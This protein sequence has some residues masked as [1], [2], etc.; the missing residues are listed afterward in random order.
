MKVTKAA[1][2][3][4]GTMGGEIAFVIASAGIPVLLKDVDQKF[5]DHGVETARELWTRL[6]EKGKLQQTAADAALAL[7][8][9]TLTYDDFGSVDFVIE[10]VPERIEIKQSVFAELDATTPGHAILASNT[11]ALSIDEI[12]AATTRPDKVVGFHFFYPASVAKLIEVIEGAATAPET[13]L[14]AYNFAQAI[15][16]APIVCGDSPGFVVNRLL[17]A[18]MGEMHRVADEHGLTP[19]QLDAAIVGMKVSPTGPCALSDMLGLDTVLHV[20]EHLNEQFG[21]DFYVPPRMRELVA[22]GDL[23]VKTGKGFYEH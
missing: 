7:I 11:S 20:L 6:V 17:C 9:G 8:E 19:E 18:S 13:A 1:V 22:A 12:S 23:G 14:A 16:K 4:A 10:A 2:V 21:D 3:G 5:V 15:K